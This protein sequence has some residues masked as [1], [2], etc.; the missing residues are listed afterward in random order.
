MTRRDLF[1]KINT[2]FENHILTS[3]M[4]TSNRDIF[5][6]TSVVQCS[7]ECETLETQRCKDEHCVQR[8]ICD[9]WQTC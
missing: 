5:W 4:I 9:R 2:A 6:K 7:N 1:G 3:A 8:W